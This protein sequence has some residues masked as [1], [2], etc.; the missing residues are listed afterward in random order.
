[1]DG[2]VVSVAGRGGS[3]QSVS[4]AW[5]G[6]FCHTGIGVSMGGLA[7]ELRLGCGSG[8]LLRGLAGKESSQLDM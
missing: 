8:R 7:G 2:F 1:M 5:T 3:V 4:A 6:R